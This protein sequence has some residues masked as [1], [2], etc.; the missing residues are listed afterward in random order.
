MAL[1]ARQ[2]HYAYS[3][4]YFLCKVQS[5]KT[6]EKFYELLQNRIDSHTIAMGST[7]VEHQD[8][9]VDVGETLWLQL[10]HCKD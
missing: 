1:R 9:E 4:L 3:I 7:L 8:E 6:Y 2:S 5:P 10:L